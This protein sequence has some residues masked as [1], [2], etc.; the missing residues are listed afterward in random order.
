MTQI[1]HSGAS[2]LLAEVCFTPIAVVEP[3]IDCHLAVT[4]LAL[5]AVG[6]WVWVD[7]NP[8]HFVVAEAVCI[9]LLHHR[10]RFEAWRISR[11]RNVAVK[12]WRI[13]FFL[14]Y[15][16]DYSCHYSFLLETIVTLVL[17]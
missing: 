3:V 7:V 8:V 12:S 16:V 17:I 9:T 10:S 6:S 1:L 15:L 14:L 2:A 5:N 13:Y 4:Y 11:R